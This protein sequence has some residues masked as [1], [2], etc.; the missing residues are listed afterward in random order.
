METHDVVVVG[1][2]D[3][4]DVLAARLGEHARRKVLLIENGNRKRPGRHFARGHR[5]AYQQWGEDWSFYDL[6]PYFKRSENA[7]GRDLILRGR[8]GPL[9][10]TPPAETSPFMTAVL[11]AAAEAG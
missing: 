3:A 8:G 1:G 7:Y 11:D 9:T 10:V 6:L 5:S 2:D 4:G